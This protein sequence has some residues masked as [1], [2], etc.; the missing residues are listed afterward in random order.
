MSGVACSM[1]PGSPCGSSAA[2]GVA[3]CANPYTETTMPI[4]G[5]PL[6]CARKVDPSHGSVVAVSTLVP[7]A[8]AHPLPYTAAVARHGDA[9]VNTLADGE[10]FD[11]LNVPPNSSVP[12]DSSSTTS[13][14]T[15]VP[16]VTPKPSA[17]HP[18]A[19]YRA[20]RDAAMP[21]ACPN[22]PTTIRAPLGRTATSFAMESSPAPSGHQLA[23]S[24]RAANRADTPPAVMKLPTAI[25]CPSGRTASA[26]TPESTP[27]PSGSH[28]LPF[29]R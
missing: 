6:A 8:P 17:D 11:K 26:S 25:S 5:M 23:P 1:Q 15:G 20:S 29:Q 16:P 3:V 27:A 19:P 24:Q 9:I 4:G 13:T 14:L 2:R 21:P 28:A 7:P 22:P 18:A 12:S 10:P